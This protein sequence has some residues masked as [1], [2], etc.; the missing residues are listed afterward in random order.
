MSS[1]GFI[2]RAS[3]MAIGGLTVLILSTTRSVLS[4]TMAHAAD[5]MRPVRQFSGRPAILIRRTPTISPVGGL[6]T[7]NSRTT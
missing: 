5:T 2:Q 7:L 1:W 3:T 6:K 4:K